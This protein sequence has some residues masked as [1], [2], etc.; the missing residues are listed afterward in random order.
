MSMSKKIDTI[1]LFL[2][3]TLAAASQAQNADIDDDAVTLDQVVPV[4]DDEPTT[5]SEAEGAIQQTQIV[6]EQRLLEEFSRYR[7]LLNE[8]SLDEADVTA[9]RIVEMAIKVYGSQSRETASA[10]NNLGIVQHSNEQFDAAIQNFIAAIEILEVEED[11]LNA[12]LVNP[13][14][15]LGAAQLGIGRPDQATKTF[16]RAAHITHVNEGPHNLDQ[17]EILESLAEAHLRMA[18]SKQALKIL[19]RIHILN[20]R[21]FEQNPMGL[22]PSLMNRATWQHRAGYY[23]DE[24][25]S[26]RRA[27][28]IVEAGAGKNDPLLI[29]PLRR[30]GKSYY[31]IS[32]SPTARQQYG[33]TSAGAMYFKRAVRIAERTE[34]LNW[35]ELATTKLDLADHYIHNEAQSRARKLYREVWEYLSTDDERLAAR[36]EWLEQPKPLWTNDLPSYAGGLEGSSTKRAHLLVGKITVDYTVSARGRV[37]NLRSEAIPPEFTDMQRMVHREIRGRTYRPK[38]EDASP[39]PAEGLEFVHTFSYLQADLDS[40]RAKIAQK[41]KGN[42]RNDSSN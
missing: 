41:A 2:I 30:L 16:N 5:D 10:L 38:I 36:A 33:L 9:K 29:E 14:K 22:L 27:I 11:R 31:F 40:L 19:D 8:G 20:V 6:T 32:T 26:Y 1:A 34:D 15:G 42:A 18:D 21:S 37:R 3:L 25:A 12:S 39:V 35:T 28:Q 17:V 24:R 23:E 13:L 7:R 4:A